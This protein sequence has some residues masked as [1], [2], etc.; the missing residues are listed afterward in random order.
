MTTATLTKTRFS[1]AK[2]N[3]AIGFIEQL[4]LTTGEWKGK[5][6]KLLPWQSKIISDVFGTMRPDGYR[7]YN[8]VY[9][10]IPK[11]NGK[12]LALDTPL[13]TPTGWT[14]MGEVKIGD[15]LFDENGK[16]C[17]I[18]FVTEIQ[19][20]HPCYEV[21]LED[22]S[23]IIADESHQWKTLCWKTHRRNGKRLH[24]A[25][26]IH[27]TKEIKDTLKLD[28]PYNIK[29]KLV[30]WNHKIAN[31]KAMEI[32]DV[33]LPIPPYTLGAWLGDGNCSGAR[34]TI[35]EPEIVEQIRAEGIPLKRYVSASY[36]GK[37]PE[38][39]LGN[40][41]RIQT[42]RNVC[43]QAKLRRLGLFHNKHIP[44]QYLRSSIK[45]RLLL[46]SGLMDT[47]GYVSDDGQCEI[48]TIYP[49]LRESILELIRSLG[50]K[51]SVSTKIARLNGKDCGECYRIQFYAHNNLQ[52]AYV[53][54]KQNRLKPLPIKP[55]RNGFRK[56][57]AVNPVESV[58][59]RCIQV[60]SS[61]HL[62]LAGAGM[63]PTHNSELAAA[64]SLY[65]LF[66]D[67]EPGAQVYLA[68]ADKDQAGIVYGAAAQ[69]IRSNPALLKR[70]KVNDSRKRIWL[71]N[72]NAFLQTLSSEVNTKHGLNVSGVVI[73][74]LHA[75]P[76]RKLYEVLTKGSGDARRQPL[77]FIITTAGIDRNSVCWELHEK[78]RG[79]LNGTLEDPAFYP[80]IY[81]PP[82]D[83]AG[84][85]WDWTSEE[86]WYKVNPSLG[87][88]VQVDKVRDAFRE[89]Q[90]K[91]EEENTFKQLRLNI[92]VKQSLRWIKLIDWDK[93]G[94]K[95]DDKELCGKP[96][97][98]A[99]DLS[100]S[101]DL[102]A[103]AH[104]FPWEDK[105]KTLMRFWIPEGIAVEKEK[106]DRVPYARWIRDGFVK[107]TPGN[108]IDY[109]FIRKQLNDDREQFDIREVAYDSWNAPQLVTQLQDDGFVI[110]DKD[111]SEGHPLLIK[112][113]QNI[114]N[115]SPA[116]KGFMDIM[117]GG[118]L[119]HG[120]NP[121]LR[122][123]AD[124]TAVYVDVNENIKPK[125]SSPTQ[126]ID[127]IITLIMALDRAMRHSSEFGKSI[128]ET[129]SLKSI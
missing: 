74:E 57:I 44:P 31:P 28:S 50:I 10:E 58:P 108:Q 123:N 61:S 71:L 112:Y 2:A 65:L 23:K 105:F 90:R 85:D 81:G 73:D 49:K 115:M 15:T 17:K 78:A 124:N 67:N 128:Y 51:V 6:F 100:T 92:W 11:K 60:D 36:E 95:V 41:I 98:S 122:W 102:T 113:P 121:V 22:G 79:I 93:C 13:P 26:Y 56:I 29:N 116:S 64:I 12:A 3:H 14:T 4:E 53:P 33:D 7:Q 106:H 109:A 18:N 52:I 5:K 77:F 110:D 32:A 99:F 129:E 101:Q 86:N 104:V 46:L 27:T 38:Y 89:A 48:T 25:D 54:R 35:S 20:N 63:V 37:A 45:Q 68:A 119:E 69:M 47:D 107:T 19:N 80:V 30:S 127:G 97:F 84:N 120:N 87:H 75:H 42:E 55:T 43:I 34:I 16:Q 1:Q 59:V 62:Y 117:L 111:Q 114:A 66:A 103:L 83:E 24:E 96:C 76:D 9:I 118:K 21:V 39:L 88:T 82:D 72:D 125:K 70:C 40:G 94:G 8:T 91:I 126:R